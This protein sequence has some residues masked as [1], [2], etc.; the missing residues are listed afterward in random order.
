MVITGH[1]SLAGT[2]VQDSCA[3]CFSSTNPSASVVQHSRSRLRNTFVE[4][5]EETL[6][7][8]LFVCPSSHSAGSSDGHE[9]VIF[10]SLAF[11][12]PFYKN[13]NMVAEQNRTML[14]QKAALQ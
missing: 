7:G 10:I 9:V 8:D 14:P 12:A 6:V 4:D 2:I 13:S 3:A 5:V 1:T 11:L